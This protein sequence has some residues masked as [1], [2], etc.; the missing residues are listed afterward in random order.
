MNITEF[1]QTYPDL[2]L[3]TGSFCYFLWK[4]HHNIPFDYY[5]VLWLFTL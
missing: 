2:I 5:D 3:K 4:V 1:I